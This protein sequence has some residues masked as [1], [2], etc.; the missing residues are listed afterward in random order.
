MAL[1][2]PGKGHSEKLKSFMQDCYQIQG[3]MQQ[4]LLLRSTAKDST[5]IA[6]SVF[7]PLLKAHAGLSW[8]VVGM[9]TKKPLSQG[10]VEIV[11]DLFRKLQP[12][13]I[14]AAGD[15]SDPHG[16]HRTCLQAILLFSFEN[17]LLVFNL[18]IAS[19]QG[20]KPQWMEKR[21]KG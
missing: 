21:V 20:T 11:V 17:S 15:L 8:C 18:P 12:R 14:Y 6:V 13:Q 1:A 2:L 3:E 10:D 19:L 9:V 4:A 5:Q 7:S 16:T